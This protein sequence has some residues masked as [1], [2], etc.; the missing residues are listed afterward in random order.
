MKHS[1]SRDVKQTSLRKYYM[2]KYTILSPHETLDYSNRST[3]IYIH[4]YIEDMIEMQAQLFCH[5][6]FLDYHEK[7]RSF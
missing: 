3:N 5:K 4:V 2:I 1:P 7:G 6:I